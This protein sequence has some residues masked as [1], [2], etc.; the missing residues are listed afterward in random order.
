[1]HT[2]LS[3]PIKLFKKILLFQEIAFY[4]QDKILAS[5]SDSKIGHIMNWNLLSKMGE[6]V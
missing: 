2:K 1:M 3:F 6:R 5:H 4:L